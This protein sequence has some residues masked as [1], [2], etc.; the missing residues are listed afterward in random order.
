VTI[1]AVRMPWIG[2]PRGLETVTTGRVID[3]VGYTLALVTFLGLGDTE[4]L[5]HAWWV[6][7]AVGAFVHGLRVATSRIVVSAAVAV[8]YAWLASSMGLLPEMDGFDFTEWPLM[9]AISL[10]VAAMADMVATSANRYAALY[11]QAS[12]RLHTAHEEE[13]ARLA[14]DLHDGVGQ[15]LTA[16]VLTLDA[17]EAALDTG[18]ATMPQVT[19]SVRRA[20]VLAASALAEARDVAGRLRPQ[21]IHEIGLGAAL[22]GLA[23]G[24]GVPVDVQLDGGLLPPG[25]LEAEREIDAYRIVQEAIGNAAR[26]SAASR[27]WMRSERVHDRVR[28]EVGDDG[29]GFDESAHHQGLGLNGMAER[30]SLLDGRLEVASQPGAGTTVRLTIPLPPTSIPASPALP[31]APGLHG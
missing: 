16:V 31:V 1:G 10:T 15:T 20:Q 27:I 18:P 7:N 24:A 14:R 2:G 13:R 26:H 4:I 19:A 22:Q 8:I 28:I 30:A 29:V 17:V 12:D 23:E 3:G 9:V 25:V 11:R 21:R 6:T 5:L